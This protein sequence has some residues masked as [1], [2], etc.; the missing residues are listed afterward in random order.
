LNRHL[1][2]ARYLESQAESAGE[3]VA[4]V[5]QHLS[6]AR[7]L[8][9]A[10]DRR[11]ASLAVDLVGWLERSGQRASALGAPDEALSFFTQALTH[12]GEG[13][14]RAR[15]TVLAAQAAS[16]GG[17]W[18]RAITLA[19]GLRDDD[20]IEFLALAATI[21][22]NALR[23]SG[24]IAQAKEEFVRFVGRARE[25]SPATAS[26][27]LR[28]AGRAHGDL[29]DAVGGRPLAEE[30]LRRAEE[31]GDPVLIGWALNDIAVLNFFAD[32][33]RVGIAIMDGAIPF[34]ERNHAAAPL[35]ALLFNRALESF[36][37]DIRLAQRLYE[38]SVELNRQT[39]DAWGTWLGTASLLMARTITGRDDDDTDDNSWLYEAVLAESE[40][41]RYM[42]VAL[43][44]LRAVQRGEVP[45]NEVAEMDDAV[46]AAAGPEMLQEGALIR[47]VRARE[48]GGLRD[49]ALA[50]AE[51]T[52]SA[53]AERGGTV[54]WF[55]Y[56]W[57]TAVDW[58]LEAGAPEDVAAARKAVAVVAES[59]A[60]REPAVTAEVL[61][62]RATVA[63]HDPAGALDDDAVERDLR[64]AID[65]LEA[66]G[67]VPHRARAQR[68]LGRF[69]ADRGRGDEA[70]A[71]LE[72]AEAVLGRAPGAPS[73]RLVRLP[74][75][76]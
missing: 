37:H 69:L 14:A 54:E 16:D 59:P 75:T 19:A 2:A 9:P 71:A 76:A 39:A 3:L 64:A 22:G 36:G 31:T 30:S 33:R 47:L 15:L 67:A 4:V 66:Y 52:V 72:A 50:L 17:H 25:L 23:L 43:R 21:R 18:D 60:R 34:C 53:R 62:L 63:L 38:R 74:D 26:T 12:A 65:A 7:D 57:S 28:M 10:S 70:T 58:L 40:A 27:L 46:I 73:L 32:L 49:Q 13:E 51:S 11:A 48:V 35:S 61:R 42:H 5:A 56:L 45:T 6:D 55:P 44:Y 29:G 41:L 20:P 1:A 24:S 8:M 68:E